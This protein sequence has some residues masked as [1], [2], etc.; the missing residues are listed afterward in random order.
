VNR[1]LIVSFFL[2]LV[3]TG[4][5]ALA[6]E[7]D[8][9][10]LGQGAP[11]LMK[12]PLAPEAYKISKARQ[13]A[14]PELLWLN[15]N[16]LR[17][18]GYAVPVEIT[19]EYLKKVY[20]AFALQIP[21]KGDPS[22]AFVGDLIDVFA[23]GYGADDTINLGSGRAASHGGIQ[24]KG[25]GA[26]QHVRDPDPWH[27]NGAAYTAEG[28]KEAFYGEIAHNEFKHGANRII[29]VI[30]TGTFG[31]TKENPNIPRAL[32]IR[33]DPTRPAHFIRNYAAKT[34]EEV[35]W[36]TKRVQAVI[37]NLGKVLPQPAGAK[38][39]GEG[40]RL[41]AGLIELTDRL[42]TQLADEYT[43]RLHHGAYSVSNA[44]M[45]G[46]SIDFGSIT[47]LDGWTKYLTDSIGKPFGD[48]TE[49]FD[50]IL[51]P[52]FKDIKKHVPTHLRDHVPT[53]AEMRKRFLGG[54]RQKFLPQRI[55]RLTGAPLELLEDLKSSGSA[56]ELGKTLINLTRAG[57][58]DVHVND[59]TAPP[60]SG[61]YDIRKITRKL[62]EG[63]PLDESDIE[64]RQLRR[65]V[66]R[67]YAAYLKDLEAAAARRGVKTESLKTYM[68]ESSEL[69][70]RKLPE[71]FNTHESFEEW[72]SR[73]GKFYEDK[74]R[75]AL[76]KYMDR[77]IERNIRRFRDVE[78]FQLVLSQVSD[79]EHGI[80]LRKV[81][82][83]KTG[84]HLDV[85]RL[86]HGEG[87]THFFGSTVE[88]K[89]DQTVIKV[90]FQDGKSALARAHKV[91][92]YY[93]YR[94]ETR[95]GRSFNPR[96]LALKTGSGKEI[97]AATGSEV[98]R[99]VAD[100]DSGC[101]DAEVLK[102]LIGA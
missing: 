49:P 80:A 42:A 38:I 6:Q 8:I 17:E 7:K 94:F 74:D 31:A 99:L 27:S 70:T 40:P 86:S 84:K 41:R 25:I 12:G 28:L 67:Q 69:M 83:A 102:K 19:P 57:N 68:I 100:P 26:T 98:A 71:T 32:I 43:M 10:E 34:A 30:S 21:A 44:L 73:A 50:W 85:I 93:E 23:D 63:S 97:A 87:K 56:N 9:L 82:D 54:Y 95:P 3:T 22:L 51:A 58:L 2:L 46:G 52:F 5:F 78:P 64:N 89:L 59:G 75:V 96:E 92:P 13:L 65:K 66:S 39:S 16:Y 47:G 18:M 1:I 24:D 76:Q 60:D 36:D 90:T 72:W 45:D 62:A 29:A 101:T 33:K 91:G 15:F 20:R 81:Y 55:L 4:S 37:K 53:V 35:A 11:H 88:A 77:R 48:P 61:K 14:K 79:T